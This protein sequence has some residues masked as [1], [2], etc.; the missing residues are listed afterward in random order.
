MTIVVPDLGETELLRVLLIREDMA[1]VPWHLH[2]YANDYTPHRESTLPDF[3]EASFPG[4]D[5]V[6]IDRAGWTLPAPVGGVAVSYWGS[7]ATTWTPSSGS[8]AVYGY[9]V[10]DAADALVLWALRFDAPQIATPGTPVSVRP[11]MRMRSL[12]EPPPP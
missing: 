1:G 4:Y 12:V 8:Q 9:F 11:F 10:T 2:L 6:E 3:T 7:S 5:V